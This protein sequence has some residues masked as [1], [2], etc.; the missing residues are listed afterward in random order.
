MLEYPYHGERLIHGGEDRMFE[1]FRVERVGG[2]GETVGSDDFEAGRTES[3]VQVR[4]FFRV[5]VFQESSD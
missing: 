4:R 5:L 2:F 3:K 1:V